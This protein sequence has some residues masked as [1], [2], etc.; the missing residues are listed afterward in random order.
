MST[1]FNIVD[2]S[3]LLIRWI[4]DSCNGHRQCAVKTPV[5]QSSIGSSAIIVLE[6]AGDHSTELCRDASSLAARIAS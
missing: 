6:R 1:T 2:L 3:S 4:Y 5:G